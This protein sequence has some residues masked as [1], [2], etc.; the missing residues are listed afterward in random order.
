MANVST[1]CISTAG[2]SEFWVWLDWSARLGV[3]P[4][5]LWFYFSVQKGRIYEQVRH[6]YTVGVCSWRRCS[7]RR[8][9]GSHCLLQ[10]V[11]R[12]CTCTHNLKSIDFC[13][14]MPVA[15]VTFSVVS[16]SIIK[17]DLI[18]PSSTR[19]LTLHGASRCASFPSVRP[20]R[21]AKRSK[22]H[23]DMKERERN[24]NRGKEPIDTKKK[25]RGGGRGKALNTYPSTRLPGPSPSNPGPIRR[26]PF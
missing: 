16:C 14:L 17:E 2:A 12:L 4:F 3:F 22:M 18:C 21:S 10:Q 8:T 11:G 1:C 9:R 5:I 13:T 19:L 23:A 6:D 20:F 26:S 24:E 15:H 7:T 25:G